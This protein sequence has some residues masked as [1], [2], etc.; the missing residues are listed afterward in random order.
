M[1][2][3]DAKDV[4]CES[5]KFKQIS[6]AKTLLAKQAEDG[7][8]TARR[9]LF[10]K[11]RDECLALYKPVATEV[12]GMMKPMTRSVLIESFVAAR[13]GKHPED[14]VRCGRKGCPPGTAA[15]V[16]C[17]TKD[18]CVLFDRPYERRTN[19]ELVSGLASIPVEKVCLADALL[20]MLIV[21]R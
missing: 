18:V 1:A 6:A 13:K 3:G 20:T 12:A 7:L 2:S 14:C 15:V 19:Q 8:D 21:H 10:R 17:E 4:K 9:R 16:L 11:Y 5:C